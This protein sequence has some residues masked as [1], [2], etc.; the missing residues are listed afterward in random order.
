MKKLSYYVAAFVLCCGVSQTLTSCVD[1]TEEPDYV[2]QV[3]EA[4]MKAEIAKDNKDAKQAGKE[5][6]AAFTTSSLNNTTPGDGYSDYVAAKTALEKAE[7]KFKIAETSISNDFAALQDKA[8]KLAG[9]AS[10]IAVNTQA[11]ED[12]NK[13]LSDYKSAFND[14]GTYIIANYDLKSLTSTGTSYK[15]GDDGAQE[16]YD[17]VITVYT[18]LIAVQQ[19]TNEK[20]DNEKKQYENGTF[21]PNEKDFQ[22][23]GDW[24]SVYAHYLGCK[25]SLEEA[26][27]KFNEK[28]AIYDEAIEAQKKANN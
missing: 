12:L 1:E 24:K 4:E 2:K 13:G 5:S 11:L 28:K 21:T 6:E 14:A 20:T 19:A 15:K 7:K 22:P 8:T 23:T 27:A 3:R 16:K 10:E 25:N 17:K 9:F 18:Y 26:Q